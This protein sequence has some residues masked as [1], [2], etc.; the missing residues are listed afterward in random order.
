[1]YFILEEGSRQETVE[2]ALELTVGS[3]SVSR[4]AERG[5]RGVKAAIQENV[6]MESTG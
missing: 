2:H 5:A 3:R 4:D 1:M 6:K